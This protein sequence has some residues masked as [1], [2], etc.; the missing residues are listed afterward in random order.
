MI[1]GYEL[2]HTTISMSKY[3]RAEA[4]GTNSSDIS[5]KQVNER[6]D[7]ITKNLQE[8][9]GGHHLKEIL[10]ERDPIVYWG[11]APTGKPH[12]GYFIPLLKIRDLVN[13]GCNVIILIADLHAFL[14][15][16][17]SPFEKIEF[18]SQYYIKVLKLMLQIL[19]VDLNKITF[20]KGSEFQLTKEVSLD[21]FKLASI[22]KVSH[23]KHS[24]AEVV[25]KSNDPYLTS[26]LYPLLQSLDEVYLKADAEL[27]GVDQRK[28][29]G[30]ARDFLPQIGYSRKFTHLMNPII[31][32]LS[33]KKSD[34]QHSTDNIEN[35]MSSSDE[36]SKIDLLDTPE[37]IK[38]NV[39]KAYCLIGDINDNS[40]LA[41]VKNLV[42]KIQDTFTISRSEENGGS[43][44]FYNYKELEN[45]YLIS[46]ILDLNTPHHKIHPMDLK[47]GLSQFLIHLLDPI[48]KEFEKDEN[49][50]LLNDAYN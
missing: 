5:E 11:T 33:R 50:K 34:T 15:N 40:V 19:N 16:L 41:M 29:F 36:S 26:L 3:S 49:V 39:N 31:S 4:F 47:N 24:G 46:N 8:V 2:Y 38:T 18:R 12:I 22:T 9:I 44:T 25:K 13:A 42:F 37:T 35:K 21:M 27:G 1:Y 10:G 6:Y 17:K 43:L 28:I 32:G 7:L 23:A 30:Y 14:D 45:A 48:R 20:V